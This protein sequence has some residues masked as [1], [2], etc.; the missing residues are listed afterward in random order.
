MTRLTLVIAA[1]LCPLSAVMAS[2]S[3]HTDYP[4]LGRDA[5]AA[6]GSRLPD[7]DKNAAERTA[8]K[9]SQKQ[10]FTIT[11][12]TDVR[13]DGRACKFEDVPGTA[14]VVA[15]DLAADGKTVVKLHFKSKPAGG[16]G[17]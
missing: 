6:P 13:L 10:S 5:L 1:L 15:I 8:Q 16:A 4:A 14:T 7:L 11:D 3:P 2:F 12:E 17:R 9:E